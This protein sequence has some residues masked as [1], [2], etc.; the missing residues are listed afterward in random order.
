MKLTIHKFLAE[1][2]RDVYSLPSR[3]ASSKLQTKLTTLQ[4]LVLH[5]VASGDAMLLEYRS[6]RQNLVRNGYIY[7]IQCPARSR[8]LNGKIKHVYRLTDRGEAA[9]DEIV[10]V[11]GPIVD[12]IN[13][14]REE[15][16]A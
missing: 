6:S 5:I 15:V 8:G 11:F 14:Q 1:L 2:A 4:C 3:K 10:R 13:V 12:K 9:H 16:T 7:G